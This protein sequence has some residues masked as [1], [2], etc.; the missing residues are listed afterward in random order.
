MRGGRRRIVRRRVLVDFR[1]WRRMLRSDD[2]GAGLEGDK[3]V[4][5]GGERGKRILSVL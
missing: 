2:C 1:R 3:S 4:G 5:D